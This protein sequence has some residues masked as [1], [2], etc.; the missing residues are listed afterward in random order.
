MKSESSKRDQ[1]QRGIALITALLAMTLLFIIGTAIV[2]SATTDSITSKVQ[3]VGEQSFFAA[4][5]GV[6]IARRAL[7]QALTEEI[8]AIRDGAQPFY[9]NNPPAS[10]GQFP[11]VQVV[12]DPDVEPNHPFYQRVYA[13]AEQ[14]MQETLRKQKFTD[15]NGSSFTATFRPLTGSVSLIEQNA[16][17]ATQVVVFRYSIQVKGKTDAGGKAQVNEVGRVS[18][19]IL[20]TYGPAPNGNRNFSF[21]GFGT[22][23]DEGDYNGGDWY[24]ASGTFSGIVH[25]NTNLAFYYGWDYKFRNVVSQ[26]N[27]KI[28]YT[29]SSSGNNNWIP[30]PTSSMSNITLSQEGYHQVNPIPLPAN[31]FSQEY[32]VINATGIT[33]MKSNG[34][35][36]DPPAV[37]PT[38][39]QGNPLPVFDANGRPNRE[40]MAANLRTTANLK[41][42]LSAGELPTGV[43][44]AS[45][46]GANLTGGGIYVQGDADDVQ[47]YADTNGDQVYVIKQGATQTTV[48]VNYSAKKT[49]VSSGSNSFT[50]NGVPIDRSD[51]ANLQNGCSFYVAGSINSLRGG[52]NENI[53][54]DRPAI[55]SNTRLTITAKRNIKITGDLKYA[56]GVVN[57][58]GTPVSNI[59]SVKNVFGLFTND[60]NI[61][62]DGKP[63]YITNGLSLQMDAA[64]CAFNNDTSNDATTEGRITSYL[65]GAGHL[66]PSDTDRFRISGSRVQKVVGQLDYRSRDIFFDARFS[67]GGFRPPFFPGTNYQ[68]PGSTEPSTVAIATIDTP[69]STAM[70]WFVDNN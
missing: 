55:A 16:T 46:D 31:T 45:A 48:R 70:S 49:S 43:Y 18:S 61:Y 39:G 35:P 50:Y 66:T 17:Q 28:R 40:V 51:P 25:T 19:N 6:R 65:G 69:A 32:A 58:D 63:E 34:T 33:D 41:P 21:S 52:I 23:F 57:S 9:K 54:Q 62:L 8:L 15:T 22:F 64:M 37:V 42:T 24:L 53:S 30:I 5:A 14:I 59:E 4:D 56:D 26:V 13:R 12:P 68:L 3:R 11:D 20:L 29:T 67:G 38:D 47:L 1:N 36:A 44:I 7:E 10:S 2:F 27:S 60:G